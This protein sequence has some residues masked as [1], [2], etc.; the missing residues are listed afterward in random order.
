MQRANDARSFILVEG[1]TDCAVLDRFVNSDHF[2]TVPALGKVRALG[3]IEQI[4]GGDR[5]T[6]VY[7]ILDRDWVGLLDDGVDYQ[8]VVYTDFYD[9][10]A[11]IFFAP[12]VY[13]ALAASFCTDMSF[14]HGAAGCRQEDITAACL[15]LALPIG[16]L[17]YISQRD[18]LGLN[19]RD[20]PLSA[21]VG[22]AGEE[23]D[24]AG[25][26]MIACKRAGT[27]PA[28]HPALASLLEAELARTRDGERY[29]SGHDLAKA[30][31][32]VA[33]RRWASNVGH[34]VIERSA[35]AVLSHDAF[36]RT[37]IF[38]DSGRWAAAAVAPV[39]RTPG[40]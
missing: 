8:T 29:C 18:G 11:C 4:H 28:D 39:W 23:V 38:R 34:D 7:A 33:R 12:E 3:A 26:I 13:E 10:D 2:V 40:C 9:L 27:E 5:I 1:P 30:F 25:L 24:I 31:A 6:A 22:G 14:K 16:L 15:R 37:N 35:R 19:L 32:L 21:V 36:T 20:F 17:R